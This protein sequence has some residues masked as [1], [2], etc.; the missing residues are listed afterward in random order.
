MIKKGDTGEG[1]VA[2]LSRKGKEENLTGKTVRFYMSNGIEG[3]AQVIDPE[4]GKV[5]YPI[6]DTFFNE[7]GYF[8]GEFKVTY[9]DGRVLSFP[10]EGFI[11][12][13]IIEGVGNNG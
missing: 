5:M 7:L 6:E 11:P 1:I 3:Y 2:V 12:I 9:E 4:N 13:R 10:G 8:Q